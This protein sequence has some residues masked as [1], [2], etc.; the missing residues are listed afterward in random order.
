MSVSEI[1]SLYPASCANTGVDYQ[2]NIREDLYG[3]SA[4]NRMKIV[5]EIIDAVRREFPLS[6]GFCVGVKLNS[7][8][9]V[10]RHSASP[11][12]SVSNTNDVVVFLRRVD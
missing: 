8:D 11:I 1:L 2:V 5:F 3:G 7:S 9:Y 4:F 6:S 12:G 10:V